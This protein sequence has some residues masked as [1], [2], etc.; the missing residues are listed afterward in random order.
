MPSFA[1]S[2]AIICCGSLGKVLYLLCT[3]PCLF[4]NNQHSNPTI[5]LQWGAET[6]MTIKYSWEQSVLLGF[7]NPKS[8][9]QLP[10]TAETQTSTLISEIPYNLRPSSQLCCS[11]NISVLTQSYDNKSATANSFFLCWSVYPSSVHKYSCL[12]HMLAENHLFF[13]CALKVSLLS[14]L[15]KLSS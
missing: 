6:G 2:S 12:F 15:F 8:K 7:Q 14:P 4:F 3:S 11:F 10:F 9:W 1:L 13:S 5:S